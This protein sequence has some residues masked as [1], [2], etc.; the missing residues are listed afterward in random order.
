MKIKLISGLMLVGLFASIFSSCDKKLDIEPQQSIEAITALEKDQ[1]FEITM[2]GAYSKIAEGALYGTNLNMLPE[3]LGNEI[4]FS[5]AGTFQS[6]RQVATKT[7]NAQNAEAART[8]IAAYQAINAANLVLSGSSKIQD[9]DLKLKLEGEA[10]FIRG[11]MHF[12]LVRLYGLPFSDG[13]SASNFGV[14]ITLTPSI[15]PTEASTLAARNTVQQVYTQVLSDLNA[16]ITKLPEENGYRANKYTA[17]SFLVR[18]YLQMGNYTMARNLADD[19]IQNSGAELTAGVAAPFKQRNSSESLFEIQQ[20]EQN[21]AGTSNDGLATFYASLPGIGRGDF[22]VL[23][24]FRSLFATTDKRRLELLYIGTGNRPGRIYSGKWASFSQNIPVIR[25]AEM[26]LTRAECN[27]RLG[28]S[29]GASPAADLALIRNRAGASAIANPT[30]ADIIKERTLELCF[31]GSRIH[32]IKRT[33]TSLLMGYDEDDNPVYMNY[34]SP[35]LVFPIPE[36][37]MR[38]NSALIQNPGYF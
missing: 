2:V 38:A 11:I 5:W 33:Q 15:T 9:E 19:I 34:N 36:R 12:E 30:V 13:N 23:S 37:E 3:L 29:V 18:V 27:L 28:T 20:N 32:D 26:Y 1:D 7:M 35:K 31:E 10:L 25:L 4:Y 22:R 21:N 14:P 24:A 16:A 6:F 17:K 8:W